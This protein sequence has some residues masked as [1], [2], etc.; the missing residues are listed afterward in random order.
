MKLRN[1]VGLVVDS[2]VITGVEKHFD[3]STGKEEKFFIVND[4]YGINCELFINQY[5]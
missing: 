2:M 3:L 1:Y 4:S 5:M